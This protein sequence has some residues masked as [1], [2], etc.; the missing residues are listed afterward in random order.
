MYELTV[1]EYSHRFYVDGSPR[2][3]EV[4]TGSAWRTIVVGTT[5]AGGK[6][7]FALDISNPSAMNSSKV[8][9]EFTH[10]DMGYT[11]GQTAIVPLPNGQFG[12]VVTSGYDTGNADGKIWILNPNDGSIIKTITVDNSGDLDAMMDHAAYSKFLEEEA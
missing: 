2:V 11:I 9:W 3:S 6:S 12:V 7:V 1:P 5:G 8:L 10:P 4:W